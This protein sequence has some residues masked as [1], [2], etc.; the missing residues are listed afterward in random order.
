MP[1]DL[2]ARLRRFVEY[3]REAAASDKLP[4]SRQWMEIVMLLARGGNGPGYYYMAGFP[5]RSISWSEKVAHLGERRYL[6]TV[7]NLNDSRYHKLSQHKLSE[8]AVLTLTGIPT[9][10]YLGYFHPHV[11]RTFQHAALTNCGQLESFLRSLGPSR[12][13]VK[14]AEGSGG[15]GFRAFEII[16]SSDAPLVRPLDGSTPITVETLHGQLLSDVRSQNG[17][18]LLIEEYLRQHPDVAALSKASVNSVR[19]WVLLGKD[20]RVRFPLAFLRMGR[21]GSLVDNRSR[22]GLVAPVDVASG[23]LS[24]AL[25][26]FP[27]RKEFDEHP[28]TGAA[29]AG[30][31]LPFWPLALEVAERAVRTFPGI[32]FAG[33]DLAFSE[34][35]PVVLELN[36][37]PD[38]T[39]AAVTGVPSGIAL[40]N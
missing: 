4:L 19:L 22:G 20:D 10:R 7:R 32:R 26:G 6:N 37:E 30:R 24:A 14:L 16:A 17:D 15:V 28:D 27:S 35:G 38:R 36:V 29:I 40:R 11:G 5:R 18:G 1:S 12:F 9:P 8:K 23:R 3:G 13:C 34:T 33:I 21:G 39:G 31:V 2:I 25:D